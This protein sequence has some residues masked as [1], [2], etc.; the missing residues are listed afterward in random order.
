MGH[1]VD[2]TVSRIAID[3]LSLRD[4]T[5]DE[6][7][8]LGEILGIVK[9]LEDIFV[10]EGRHVSRNATTS[11]SSIPQHTGVASRLAMEIT[12][13]SFDA[14]KQGFDRVFISRERLWAYRLMC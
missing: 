9:G 10:L 8:K 7:V 1:L 13:G 2:V 6:S 14:I 5:E 11:S 3:I 4:I 12:G